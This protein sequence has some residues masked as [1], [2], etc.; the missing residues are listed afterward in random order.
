MPPPQVSLQSFLSSAKRCLDDAIRYAS[1]VTFVIGNES[2]GEYQVNLSLFYQLILSDLDSLCSAVVLAYLR[3]HTSPIG[4]LYIPLSNLPRADLALRPELIPV[5]S[6]AN[7]KPS[8]LITLSDLPPLKTMAS[9]LPPENT[10]WILVD[11]NAMR[12]EMGKIYG[13]Q[14]VGCIDH[15]AEENVVPKDCGEQP[16]IVRKCG[17][18]ITLVL[19]FCKDAWDGIARDNHKEAEVWNRELAQVALGPILIDTSNLENKAETTPTDVDAIEYLESWVKSDPDSKYNRDDYYRVI[20]E[21]KQDIGNLSVPDMLR[22]DYKEYGDDKRALNLGITSTVRSMSFLIDEAGGKEKFLETVKGFASE[23]DLSI[24]SLMT[25]SNAGGK[26]E[27]E[28]FVWA[29][30]EQGVAAAKK[31]EANA[32]KTLGLKEWENGFLDIDEEKHWQR[33]W[34]QERVENSRKQVAPLMRTAIAEVE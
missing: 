1:P 26:F 30:D 6:H 15:H 10:R 9:K 34:W 17:S 25:K 8:D 16:R 33:C 4:S 12:G 31:F 7:L 32:T 14:L 29:S 28:L 18:C 24:L 27:R 13:K 5:L 20:S 3:T 2:A 23:R 19:E 11:H 22:K 21:A